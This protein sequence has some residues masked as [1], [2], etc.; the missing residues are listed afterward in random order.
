MVATYLTCVVCGPSKRYSPL[1]YGLTD[2]TQYPSHFVCSTIHG[3]AY[4][5]M[6][7]SKTHIVIYGHDGNSAASLS[8]TPLVR[9]FEGTYDVNSAPNITFTEMIPHVRPLH[10]CDPYNPY[11]F[12][13]SDMSVREL[14]G[15][16]SGMQEVILVAR[17]TLPIVPPP[18]PSDVKKKKEKKKDDNTLGAELVEEEED[19]PR[20]EEVLPIKLD[21]TLSKQKRNAIWYAKALELWDSTEYN[22]QTGLFVNTPMPVAHGTT[23]PGMGIIQEGDSTTANEGSTPCV[24]VC[25]V[26]VRVK[27][28]KGEDGGEVQWVNKR[29]SDNI[30]VSLKAIKQHTRYTH[31]EGRRVPRSG[32]F[33]PGGHTHTHSLLF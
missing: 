1:C 17:N 22:A 4:E 7:R 31:T 30:Y 11:V 10:L 27:S 9:I 29:C 33:G 14:V 2:P 16:S 8:L 28:G 19:A 18:P 20:E 32:P 3:E 13:S 23:L 15:K 12:I 24:A 21:G 25:L 5:R 26:R 6:K